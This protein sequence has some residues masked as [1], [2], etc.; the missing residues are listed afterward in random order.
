MGFKKTKQTKAQ[1]LWSNPARFLLSP[2]ASLLCLCVCVWVY[3]ML[4][5]RKYFFHM[6]N[7]HMSDARNNKQAQK[8]IPNTRAHNLK[9]LWFLSLKRFKGKRSLLAFLIVTQRWRRDWRGCRIGAS[10]ESS[11]RFCGC[12]AL[13]EGEEG[14]GEAWMWSNGSSKSSDL[15][16]QGV[17][18]YDTGKK[19][20]NSSPVDWRRFDKRLK[21]AHHLTVVFWSLILYWRQTKCQRPSPSSGPPF[22]TSSMTFRWSKALTAGAFKRGDTEHKVK[23]SP[24]LWTR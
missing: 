21:K 22:P 3:C 20:R 19:V 9:S 24:N 12:P 11:Q 4:G 8:T 14:R 16:T 6:K 7:E 1:Q 13:A 18:A 2:L 5:W 17:G 15:L 23:V 10:L